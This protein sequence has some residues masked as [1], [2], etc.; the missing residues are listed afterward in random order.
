[1]GVKGKRGN[2]TGEYLKPRRGKESSQVIPSYLSCGGRENEPVARRKEQGLEGS[3][4]VF[5]CNQ[6][7]YVDLGSYF[8]WLLLLGAVTL[9]PDF[10]WIGT[11]QK[12]D[13]GSI[14]LKSAC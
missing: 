14:C 12:C 10:S 4:G 8:L 13:S 2:F 5:L 3:G 1:M 11:G 7:G 6:A 9:R